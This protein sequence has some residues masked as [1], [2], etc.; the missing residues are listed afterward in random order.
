MLKLQGLAAWGRPQ[1][2]EGQQDWAWACLLGR[3]E[4]SP[5]PESVSPSLPFS[6]FPLLLLVILLLLLFPPPLPLPV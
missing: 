6:S 2:Q 1:R 5:L 3:K 4:I